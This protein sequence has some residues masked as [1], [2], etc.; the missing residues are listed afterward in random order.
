M[1]D[2]KLPEWLDLETIPEE[3]REDALEAWNKKWLETRIRWENK[4]MGNLNKQDRINCDYCRNRGWVSVLE[5]VP[6]GGRVHYTTAT[7]LCHCR[8]NTFK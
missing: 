1:D 3:E 8:Y 6:I 7:K 5:A 2:D 4:T